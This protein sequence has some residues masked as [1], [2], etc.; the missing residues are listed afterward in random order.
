MEVDQAMI[1]HQGND[2]NTIADTD[3]DFHVMPN[4]APPLP[5]MPLGI[6]DDALSI[7]NRLR[8]KNLSRVIIGCL[9]IN[10]IRNK[11]EMLS[12]IVEGKLD[13][14]LISEAKIDQSF[15]T[16]SFLIPGFCTP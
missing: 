6:E 1:S 4:S 2:A 16:S 11:V 9:N 13:I 12:K 3:I 14:L 5:S 7:L 8:I 10:S 15:P